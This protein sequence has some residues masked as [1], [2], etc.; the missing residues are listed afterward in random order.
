MDTEVAAEK[1]LEAEIAL[2]KQIGQGDR[3][4]FETRYDRFSRVLFFTA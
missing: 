4:S 3:R 1:E 2:L